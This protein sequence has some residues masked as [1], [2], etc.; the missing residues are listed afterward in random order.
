MLTRKQFEAWRGFRFMV[1]ETSLSVSRKLFSSTGMSG[2]Q[3]GILTIL[4]E[5]PLH[6]MRQQELADAMRWDRTRLS[7]QLKRMEA[8]GWIKRKKTDK[9]A[10]LVT[11]AEAG[12]QEQHRAA[13]VLSKIVEERF[14]NRL[15]RAQLTMLDEI[16]SALAIE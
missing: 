5:A 3:F 2:G 8:R 12:R 13:P 10:T 15:T 4:V 14:F 9:G 1:E 6:L 7:H 11:L 16:R